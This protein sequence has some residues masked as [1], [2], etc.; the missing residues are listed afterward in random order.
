MKTRSG[1]GKVDIPPWQQHLQELPVYTPGVRL[2]RDDR[3]RYAKAVVDARRAGGSKLGIAAFL[4]CSFALVQRLLDLGEGLDEASEAHRVETVLRAGIADGTY[5]V[6]DVLPSPDRLCVQL[7]V[8]DESVRR[9]L[10]RLA[11]EG[12]TLGISALGTVVTNPHAPPTGSTLQVRT[13]SGQIQTWTLPMTQS[14]HIRA[15]ITARITD[16]TYPEGSKIPGIKAL[17]EEF[18]ATEGTLK[19]A[20][21]PLKKRGILS[22]TRQEGTFVHSSARSLL[23]GAEL[24][25]TAPGR[26]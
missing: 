1:P 25:G 13:R 23:T 10:A 17:T 5:Q 6:G 14:P 15:V 18:G 12:L 24:D 7:G 8:R 26:A 11:Q 20:L 4:G 22:G 16:G 21:R 2:T 19:S 3:A 9:A